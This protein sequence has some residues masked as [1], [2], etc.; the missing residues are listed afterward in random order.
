LCKEQANCF[1]CERESKAGAGPASTMDG[2]AV[3]S[4]RSATRG[5]GDSLPRHHFVAVNRGFAVQA[6]KTG[7]SGFLSRARKLL[8]VSEPNHF[9]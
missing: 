7:L 6:L 3:P 4:P 1:A 2:E 5:E 9:A 8:V